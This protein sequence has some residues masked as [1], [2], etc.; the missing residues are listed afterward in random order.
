MSDRMPRE[1][2]AGDTLEFTVS[3]EDYPAGTWTLHYALHNAESAYQFQASASGSDHAV[4]VAAST[5]ANYQ[6]GR[7]DWTAWVTDGTDRHVI[8]DGSV[9]VL[10]D[11]SS[12][13][14]YDGRSHAEVMLEAI[15]A[16]LESRATDRQIDLLEYSIGSRSQRWSPELLMQLR[17]KYKAEVRNQRHA[18]RLR[19]GDRGLNKIRTRFV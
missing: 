6:P 15:E 5:T 7:Y 11:P 18:E 4:S 10:R 9:K 3:L 16:R 17:D 13:L 19:R 2:T 14:P 1:I 12:S 8:A